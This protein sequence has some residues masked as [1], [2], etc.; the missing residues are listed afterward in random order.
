MKYWAIASNV[1]KESWA[2]KTA[3]IMTVLV[4]ILLA[5]YAF[6]FQLVTSEEDDRVLVVCCLGGAPT[7]SQLLE[8]FNI[9][10]EERSFAI[11]MEQ[12]VLG[13]GMAA[14]GLL[15][16]WGILLGLFITVGTF[17]RTFRPRRLYW[18][19]AKPV[20]RS[21]LLLSK[22]GGA[23]SL[24]FVTSMVF[25]VCM[26]ML[27]T[28]KSGE[29]FNARLLLSGLLFVFNYAVLASLAAL[30]AVWTQNTGVSL[31][32]AMLL[33]GI[34][35]LLQFLQGPE[36]HGFLPDVL[37]APVDAFYLILPKLAGVETLATR[38]LSNQ[39]LQDLP[40]TLGSSAAFLVAMLGLSIWEFRR[41]DY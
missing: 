25:I 22:Y 28:W 14:L 40:L 24:V 17:T 30:L 37:R 9:Y 23:V 39:S 32:G 18:I 2:R 5:I 20:S 26:A 10:S 38:L 29:G 7:R 41:R 13:S 27:I 1:W 8:G 6:G 21:G 36:I 3:I 19:L 33:Y 12:F 11:S 15:N 4:A 34:S 16:P 31:L 35:G